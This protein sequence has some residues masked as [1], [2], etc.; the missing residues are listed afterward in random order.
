M[1]NKTKMKK[2]KEEL[3]AMLLKLFQKYKGK[4]H[5]QIWLW[6]YPNTKPG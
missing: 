6:C 5:Y 2:K 3:P 1:N 4:E